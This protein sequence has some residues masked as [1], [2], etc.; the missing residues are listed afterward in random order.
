VRLLLVIGVALWSAGAAGAATVQLPSPTTPLGARPPIGSLAPG[1]MQLPQPPG[2]TNDQEVLADVS[3][4]GAVTRVRVRQRLALTGIGDFFF[5]LAAPVRDIRALPDSQS[6]P[7]LR[8]AAVVWQGFSPGRRLLAAELELEPDAVASALPLRVE[9]SAGGVTLRNATS[10][11]VVGFV[12]RAQRASVVRLLERIA[13]RQPIAAPTVEIEGSTAQRRLRVDAPLRIHGTVEHHGRTLRR[14]RLVL[15]GPRPLEATIRAPE[16][17]EVRLVAEPVPLV[18]EAARP[19]R[20]ATAEELLLLAQRALLRLA[21]VN[22]YR[23]FIGSPAPGR[24]D[25]SYRLRV[26]PKEPAR[27]TP[28]QSDGTD[29]LLLFALGAGAVVALGGALVAWAHL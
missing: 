9:R 5:Q 29:L 4:S 2:V 3:E 12:A 11:H 16:G 27:P 1:P 6:Q 17:A 25:A 15:G 26:V 23:T 28:P 10:V 22:Q 13:D 7:G 19:P 24:A 8:R 21:R 14:V 18:P 20:N